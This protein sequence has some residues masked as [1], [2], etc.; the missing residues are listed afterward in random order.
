MKKLIDEYV[1]GQE[2]I[3]AE[4]KIADAK[5]NLTL[6]DEEYK[7]ASE[8]YA[9]VTKEYNSACE[10]LIKAREN[11]ERLQKTG[12]NGYN[13]EEYEKAVSTY[14]ELNKKTDELASQ[15]VELQNSTNK[16]SKS[17]QKQQGIIN[18]LTKFLS[19]ETKAEKDNTT[20]KNNNTDATKDNTE[21]EKKK[22]EQYDNSKS[23]MLE[24]I[25]VQKQLNDGQSLSTESVLNLIEK[26]PQLTT[27]IKSTK[28]G[29]IIETDAL[30]KLIAARIKNMQ[31]IQAE[32]I[33]KLQ[34]QK[35]ETQSTYKKQITDAEN[36]IISSK[37]K[38]ADIS[39]GTGA[40]SS[41]NSLGLDTDFVNSQ[42]R[43]ST[44]S[45]ITKAMNNATKDI[46]KQIA[47][48]EK[49]NAALNK[50]FS[51]IQTNGYKSGGTST[52]NST[53]STTS[54]SY[55]NK[56]DKYKKHVEK[57]LETNEYKYN[58][59]KKSES[60]YYAT[61]RKI[62]DK[63]YT[64]TKA[65]QKKYESEIS[66]IKL[67]LHDHAK[68]VAERTAEIKKQN[69]EK[70][71]SKIESLE[72]SYINGSIK[73]KNA[74]V[75]QLKKLQSSYIDSKTKK[76]KKGYEE[77]NKLLKQ[78]IKNASKVQKQAQAE[79]EK[80]ATEKAKSTGN[81]K[82][83]YYDWQYN[84]SSQDL[85]AKQT[86][87]KHYQD[88]DNKYYKN[89]KGL[90]EEHRQ[91]LLKI[92]NLQDDI[93][94]EQKRLA[95]E[96]LNN[97]KSNVEKQKDALTSQLDAGKIDAFKYYQKLQELNDKYYKHR[98]DCAE[99]YATLQKEINEGI[100]QAQEDNINNITDLA[101]KTN[102]VIEA[103]EKLRGAEKKQKIYYDSARGF[104]HG[105]DI[106]AVT[107][108]KTNLYNSQK[109]L[110]QQAI[111]LNGNLTASELSKILSNLPSFSGISLP[112][113]TT[114]TSN[115]TVSNS[116]VFSG[117]IKTENPEDFLRQI[118]DYV[119]Q[120]GID[121]MIGR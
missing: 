48:A 2:K 28:D 13:A 8:E 75:A 15:Q 6:S 33:A 57:L 99:E 107:E 11:L 18:T 21:A 35:E 97:Y 56:E 111:S 84:M 102:S 23:E 61:I 12:K 70:T 49:Q 29:Y 10:Q 47:A 115:K 81:S 98:T 66:E 55:K 88:I 25:Q 120:S 5:V 17:R 52:S 89:K 85:K 40:K 19:K 121:L 78:A 117:D 83:S 16:L 1:D 26:Y 58:M 36:K 109:D 72:N 95:E 100:R 32:K 69:A 79:A 106:T 76:V 71:K 64:N 73:S 30:N 101:E 112:S 110:M 46:D 20:A 65:H 104:Y 4:Q 103:T 3:L 44:I 24:L 37:I 27:A 9:K 14:N 59:G 82:E 74:Y 31:S 77:S 118:N 45:Q 42:L 22:Q 54:K 119:K 39:K 91:M 53:K 114:N 86:L 60:A 38:N 43:Q 87:L 80:R 50:L 93:A 34:A 67:Q 92:K 90:A 62:R 108:A 105:T 68:E 116:F 51:D 94:S 7:Q 63:Y 41:K 113:T 96:N